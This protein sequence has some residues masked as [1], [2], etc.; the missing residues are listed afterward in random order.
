MRDAEY[1]YLR[2]IDSAPRVHDRRDQVMN[3]TPGI[4]ADAI[5]IVV[6]EIEAW[7]LAGLDRDACA[8]LGI[9]HRGITDDVTKERLEAMQPSRYRT[10]VGFLQDVLR[11]FSFDTANER[12]ASFRYFAARFDL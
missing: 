12:N 11:R 2:D 3:E 4:R 8:E 6:P 1:V 5:V 7:Y 10:R 9:V